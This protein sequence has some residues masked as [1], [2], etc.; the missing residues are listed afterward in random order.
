MHVLRDGSSL[1]QRACL[2]IGMAL[3]IVTRTGA[4]QE[5]SAAGEFFRAATAAYARGDYAAAARAFEA[6][7]Q[8][9]PRGPTMYNA[10]LSW[11]EAGQAA[12]AAD[13]F[14]LALS[15]GQLS[16]EQQSDAEQ[17]LATTSAALGVL[18]VKAPGG[19]RV[20][21]A[22]ARDIAAPARIHLAPGTY[23]VRIE[24]KDGSRVE[25]QVQL[26]ASRQTHVSVLAAPAKRV[27]SNKR[28]SP[29]PAPSSPPSSD[30]DTRSVIGYSLVGASVALS[31]AAIVLGL[32][33][34]ESR[35][36]FE[37][38]GRIDRDAH[39]RAGR[40]RVWTN[41]AWAG[42]ALTGGAGVYLLVTQ[43][44]PAAGGRGV[45]RASLPA[46][47]VGLRGRF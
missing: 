41:L 28:D 36:Q 38:S 40:L 43:P 4:A 5:E 8:R 13:A 42:A 34:L 35:D 32:D 12:R 17:R 2:A 31:A 25:R 44:T 16:A 3:L 29:A 21:V 18:S 14:A 24:R 27:D 39:E 15:T 6:A 37:D 11:Q 22:H 1:R 30:D 33:A 26:K 19:S 20:S 9:A 45:G 46:R 23:V 10:G 7:H 47:G